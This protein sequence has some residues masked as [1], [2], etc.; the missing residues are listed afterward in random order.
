MGRLNIIKK[1]S[2]KTEFHS[3]CTGKDAPSWS[4]GITSLHEW[5]RSLK[6]YNEWRILVFKK[7][8]YACN[9]CRAK[10]RLQAH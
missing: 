6:E 1:K 5:I 3:D 10:R 4:G 2:L 7:D 8:N 9:Q